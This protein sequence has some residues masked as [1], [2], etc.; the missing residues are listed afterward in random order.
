MLYDFTQNLRQIFRNRLVGFAQ[1]SSGKRLRESVPLPAPGGKRD[2]FISRQKTTKAL[3][4]PAG[5]AMITLRMGSISTANP[6]AAAGSY[7]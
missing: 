5:C 2:V 3:Y 4:F 6:A 1:E 7:H